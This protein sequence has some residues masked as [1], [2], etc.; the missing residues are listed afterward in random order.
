MVSYTPKQPNV[1]GEKNR[2]AGPSSS[3]CIG[4]DINRNWPYK[5]AVTGGASTDPCAED[6]KGTA[7]ASATENPVLSS[8]VNKLAAAQTVRAYVDMHSY[9]QLFMTPYGYSCSATASNNAKEQSLAKG[10][11]S[12]IEAVYGT[13]YQ[14]GPICTTIYEAT[15]NSV[16]YVKDKSGVTYPFTI[17]LRDT[18]TN[19]FVLPKSQILPSGIETYAGFAY[20]FAN[21]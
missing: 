19:G 3:S 13:S 5:W 6:Y 9:S 8:Y 10:V 11:A 1:F 16:D 7:A 2:Q 15:G 4:T 17:E 18:G 21:I 14:Y 20:L 12:A